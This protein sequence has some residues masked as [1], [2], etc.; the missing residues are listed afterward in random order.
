MRGRLYGLKAAP[1]GM[2]TPRKG[3]PGRYQ[4]AQVVRLTPGSG[5]YEFTANGVCQAF[6]WGS[7]ASGGSGT[8]VGG[9][10]AG[11]ACKTF[12]VIKGQRMPYTVSAGAAASTPD[13]NGLD[14]GDTTFTPPGGLA[15]T[16]K[17]GKGSGAAGT[18]SGGD[19]NASGGAAG[20]TGGA[21]GATG[22]GGAA[23]G[24]GA[25][26]GAGGGG[27]GGFGSLQTSGGLTD[28]LGG[29][30]GAGA[31]VGGGN[32]TAPGGGGGSSGSTGN[33]GGLGGDGRIVL[34]IFRQL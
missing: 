21:N 20:A 27:A 12:P 30:G 8:S 14:G 24:A 2:A 34:F 31:N 23:G 32:G 1:Q 29:V 19:V 22:S 11:A 16:A 25:F 7:G 15:V 26:T 5:A 6:S 10:G 13:A 3:A 17:G 9:G 33:P 28:L 4:L 18:A